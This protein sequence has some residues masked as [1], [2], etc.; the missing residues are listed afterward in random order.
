MQKKVAATLSKR[1]RANPNDPDDHE[2][3]FSDEE[4]GHVSVESPESIMYKQLT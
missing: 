2:Q 1:P 4:P 3:V